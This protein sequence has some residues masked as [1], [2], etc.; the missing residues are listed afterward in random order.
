[1]AEQDQTPID[2]EAIIA[3][4]RQRAPDD[5]KK[6]ESYMI[7]QA[8]L[9]E[10]RDAWLMARKR[11]RDQVARGETPTAEDMH[12]AL[13]NPDRPPTLDAARQLEITNA[14]RRV[15]QAA[16]KG[17]LPDPADVLILMSEEEE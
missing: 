17:E 11:V 5:Q 16:A 6:R 15:R 4:R 10:R 9:A 13:N 7:G 3:K 14:R 12:L 1:M 2:F 8:V